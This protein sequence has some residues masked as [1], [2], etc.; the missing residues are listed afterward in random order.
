MSD[1]TVAAPHG[2]HFE[3]DEVRTDKG[4]KSLGEVPILVWDDVDAL[5]ACYGK[6][7]ILAVSDGT[8]LRVSFQ[9]I[10]RRFSAAG[11]T[12]DEIAKAQTEFRP[13]KRVGGVSTPESRAKRA[14]GSASEK[15]GGDLIESLLKQVAEGKLSKEDLQ[16]LLGS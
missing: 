6:E 1:L 5:V 9:S 4:T 3:F 13:G 7:G 14:A 2:A 10:A 15:V 16:S 11:K 12:H 8:S